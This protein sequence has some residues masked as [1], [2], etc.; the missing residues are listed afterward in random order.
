MSIEE[1][2]RAHL[3]ELREEFNLIVAKAITLRRLLDGGC[4]FG[5]ARS[6]V[7]RA[8]AAL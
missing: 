1:R 4:D 6:A 2:A 8:T 7:V 3:L 5:V